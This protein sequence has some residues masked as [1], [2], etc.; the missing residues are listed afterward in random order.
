[1][2]DLLGMADTFYQY[3]S[4]VARDFIFFSGDVQTTTIAV[5][6][7][8]SLC[9]SIVWAIW[10]VVNIIQNSN[11]SN[12][13]R[14]LSTSS[15]YF[16]SPHLD[17]TPAKFS[18]K[19]HYDSQY[20]EG[21]LDDIYNQQIE[22][23]CVSKCQIK[24]CPDRI[25]YVGAQLTHLNLSSNNLEELP[26]EIGCLRGLQELSVSDNSIQELPE[27][28]GT[29][30]NLKIL[31]LAHNKIQILPDFL[32][33]LTCLELLDISNN[34]LLLLPANIGELRNLQLLYAGGNKLEEIPSGLYSLLSLKVLDIKANHLQSLQDNIKQLL[35]LEVLDVTDCDLDTFP[36]GLVYCSSLI[37]LHA[38]F[39]RY[40]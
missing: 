23:P 10:H 39:N 16:P 3:L 33:F 38:A 37:S 15:T 6:I 36:K 25:G 5:A 27:S 28:L 14:S 19:F 8:S 21:L 4:L 13:R 11:S 40:E 2:D 17:K 7:A 26:S 9:C 34:A 18:T 30:C 31:K 32:S 29:L 12:K 35:R 22:V 20:S 1:M 24:Q